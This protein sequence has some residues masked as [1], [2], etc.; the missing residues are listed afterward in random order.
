MFSAAY[1]SVHPAAARSLSCPARLNFLIRSF[2]RPAAVRW[3]PAVRRLPELSSAYLRFMASEIF[4]LAAALILLFLGS[5]EVPAGGGR[6]QDWRL[7]SSWYRLRS[8][9]E[10][11]TRTIGCKTA[12]Q[13]RMSQLGCRHSPAESTGDAANHPSLGRP[14]SVALHSGCQSRPLSDRSQKHCLE[15]H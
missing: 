6:T 12:H 1:C 15:N 14:I 2:L 13:I 10:A 9:R 4:F 7:H 5:V 11:E 8:H 3:L